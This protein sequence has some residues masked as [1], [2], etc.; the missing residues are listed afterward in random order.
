MAHC[1]CPKGARKVS[2]KPKG[3][4]G[5]KPRGPGF[6]CTMKLTRDEERKFKR[7]VKMRRNGTCPKGSKKRSNKRGGSVCIGT[8][9]ALRKAGNLKGKPSRK[10]VSQVCRG[11]THTAMR[12]RAKKRRRRRR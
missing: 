5:A 3:V 7:F 1:R 9:A 8:V 10:F 12:K 2:T 6:V 11:G 4:K